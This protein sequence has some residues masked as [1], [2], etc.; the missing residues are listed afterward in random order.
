MNKKSGEEKRFLSHFSKTDFRYWNE[1]VF[2]KGYT[3]G[4]RQ[5]FTKDWYA[6]IQHDGRRDFFSL[7]TP[8]K[9]AAASRAKDIYLYLISHGWDP[10][11]A[12]YKPKRVEDQATSGKL[13]QLTVGA[14]LDEVFRSTSNRRTVEGYAT[15]FRT[16]VSENFG[17]SDDVKKYDAYH[18]GRTEWL[19]RVHSISL[20]QVTP[21]RIQKWKQSF[22]AK[23]GSEALALRKARISVNS[24]MRRARSLF[25]AKILRHL[26]LEIPVVNPF[27]GVEFE[28][29]QSM[30]YRSRVDIGKILE[31]A[32][33]SLRSSDPECYAIFLLAVA[34]GLR[35]KEIDLLEWTSFRCEENVIRIQPTNF[36]HPKS[37]DSIGDIQIDDEIMAIFRDYRSRAKGPFVIPSRLQ[38]KAVLRGDYYRCKTQFERLNTWLRQQGVTEQK[39]LHTLR[40]EFGTLV[41]VAHGIHAA[42]KALRHADI[43]LTSNFYTDSRIRVTS[44]LGRLFPREAPS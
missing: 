40:K 39:P 31:A 11:I 26:Q 35:R 15:A 22:L 1:T 42:S 30:K 2:R 24:L 34:A 9:A 18:G 7:Q 4:G 5:H 8:N 6:R 28:P 13:P 44:G 38:P 17:L 23:A 16:I 37:E 21:T 10:T 20:D 29:R 33:E 14:F 41:N 32:N 12:K 36:F 27:E 25:S 43:T 3:K 19:N